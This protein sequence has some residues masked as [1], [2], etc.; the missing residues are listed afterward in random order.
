MRIHQDALDVYSTLTLGV[1][2]EVLNEIEGI[3]NLKCSYQ[4]EGN[5]L[6]VCRLICCLYL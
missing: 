6:F 1:F 4:I 3:Y 2:E 5:G